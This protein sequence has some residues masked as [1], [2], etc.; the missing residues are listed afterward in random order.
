MERGFQCIFGEF[1]SGGLINRGKVQIGSGEHH[2]DNGHNLEESIVQSYYSTSR[3]DNR[4]GSGHLGFLL[5]LQQLEQQWLNP[6]SLATRVGA[7]ILGKKFPPQKF[8]TGLIFHVLDNFGVPIIQNIYL[9]H[10]V[11]F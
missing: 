6:H 10:F 11:E 7:R 9:D 5:G 2:Q 4:P 8:Q 3:R 1:Y